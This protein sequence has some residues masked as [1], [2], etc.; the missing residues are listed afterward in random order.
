MLDSEFVSLTFDLR[1]IGPHLSRPK[2][3]HGWLSDVMPKR[4]KLARGRWFARWRV[5]FRG[6]D[7]Q[8]RW[9][10]CEKIIDRALAETVG[11][12]FDSKGPLT[13]TDAQ[14]V[15]QKLIADS[16]AAPVAVLLG[17]L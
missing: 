9:K 16:N 2:S 3:Q 15:L 14:K 7:G 1:S 13:K 17:R 10:W 6:T 11:F 4:G 5:Y 8:E 12:V